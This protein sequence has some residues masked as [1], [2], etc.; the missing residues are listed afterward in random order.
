MPNKTTIVGGAIAAVVLTLVATTL[1]E[2]HDMFLKP[3]RY[4]IEPNAATIVRVLNGTFSKSENSIARTRLADIAVA[5]PAGRTRLDTSHWSVKGDTSTFELKAS[6]VGTYVLGVSTKPNFIALQAKDFNSYLEEDG[7]RDILNA[8][9]KDGEMGK[10][11]RERYSKHVKALVQVGTAR[12]VGALTP[13]GYPAEIVPMSNPYS[14]RIGDTLSI[15]TFVEGKPAGAQLVQYGGRQLSGSNIA[16]REIRSDAN[17]VAR[18]KIAV[19]G[20]WYIKFINMTR[21]T[22]DTVDYESRW[23]T[24]TFQLR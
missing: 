21:V 22:G 24:L 8:R 15:R 11:A 10:P 17:G 5:G 7:I 18:I 23:A 1:A 16:Q 19:A 14:L 2:A 6:A 20:V 12:S 13:L 3:V 4:Y 9:R